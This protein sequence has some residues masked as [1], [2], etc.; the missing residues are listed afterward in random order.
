MDCP[1]CHVPPEAELLR[2]QWF[3]V[4]GKEAPAAVPGWLVISSLTHVESLDALPDAALAELGPLSARLSRAL[5]SV[6]AA[7]R[8]YV[9]QLGEVL[10]HLH[11][12]VIARP[13]SLPPVHR[14][15]AIF[16]APGGDPREAA[17]LLV[18][19]RVALSE[20]GSPG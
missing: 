10:R 6:T 2:T 17:A 15:G 9:V 7:E 18:R 4:R 5:R 13:P 14:G 11:V 19:L 16:A 8:I 20:R 12:H 3:R 1:E